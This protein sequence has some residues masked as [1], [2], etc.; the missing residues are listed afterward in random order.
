MDSKTIK[1][2]AKTV[3]RLPISLNRR[4]GECVDVQCGSYRDGYVPLHS[5]IKQDHTW[6][7]QDELDE[8][9]F[10]TDI[11]CHKLVGTFR[12]TASY[13]KKFIETVKPELL[14]QL[15]TTSWFYYC[16]DRLLSQLCSDT[17]DRNRILGFREV[18]KSDKRAL[19]YKVSDIVNRYNM[20][21]HITSTNEVPF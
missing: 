2:L 18:L 7:T 15:G 12:D 4:P 10:L 8:G 9:W 16:I 11:A 17:D 1:L 6:G 5:R 3:I 21:A 20:T 14:C 13:G 19:E